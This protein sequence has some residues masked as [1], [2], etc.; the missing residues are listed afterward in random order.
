MDG[1]PE[2]PDDDTASR[3]AARGPELLR[4]LRRLVV[5]AS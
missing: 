2:V 5:H 3:A 4:D 1:Q